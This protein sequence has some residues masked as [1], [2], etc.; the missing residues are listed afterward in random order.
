VQCR[1]VLLAFAAFILVTGTANMRKLHRH[2]LSFGLLAA[3]LLLSVAANCS[4]DSFQVVKQPHIEVDPS[5]LNFQ[6]VPGAEPT[7]RTITIRNSGEGTLEL[8]ALF[9][10][11]A[12]GPFRLSTTSTAAPGAKV[13]SLGAGDENSLPESLSVD[14]VYTPAALGRPVEGHLVIEHNDPS[15][16]RTVVPVTETMPTASL[17]VIPSEVRFQGVSPGKFAKEE[18]SILNLGSVPVAIVSVQLV[19][20]ASFELLWDLSDGAAATTPGRP[21]VLDPP[22]ALPLGGS[23]TATVRFKPVD[24]LPQQGEL[25]VDWRSDTGEGILVV[26]IWGNTPGPC[27]EVEPEHLDFGGVL[28]GNAVR[29]PIHIRSCGADPIEVHSVRLSDT[30]G[31][32]FSLIKEELTLDGAPQAWPAMNQAL[33]MPVNTT[34]SFELQYLPTVVSPKGPDG[35][36]VREAAQILV[37]SST[38]VGTV[39]VD[40]TG[41][42]TDQECPAAVISVIEGAS[43]VAPQTKLRL[44][45]EQSIPVNGTI[46]E[47]DWSVEQPIG[48]ADFFMPNS[49]SS[50]VEITA[51]TAGI[52]L[53][54]LKVRDQGTWSCEPAERRILVIPDEAIHVHLIWEN[55]K[56]PDPS[57]KIGTDMDLHFV[58]LDN[59]IGDPQG[60]DAYPPKP[61]MQDG[62]NEGYFH[63]DWDTYFGYT[64]QDWGKAGVKEDDPSLDRDDIDGAGPE[65]LNLNAPEQGVTY[66]IGVHYF[67]SQGIDADAFF[68]TPVE[69]GSSTPIVRIFLFGEMVAE[70]VGCPM[71]NDDMWDVGTFIGSTGDLSLYQCNAPRPSSELGP[72]P[73]APCGGAEH[74]R[75]DGTDCPWVIYPRYRESTSAR[76][77]LPGADIPFPF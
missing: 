15:G 61:A 57:D 59:A 26:P 33:G 63:P 16:G 39:T 30:S 73:Q 47:Y 58:H 36:V 1:P 48:S 60:D 64:T 69:F 32:A 68:P 55:A 12:N 11:P 72:W 22:E 25:R 6:R 3:S 67:S 52:Y 49:K 41:F 21:I 19:G 56:D 35:E 37:E 17:E 10:E 51:N 20:S 23:R 46:G 76:I 65:N 8:S 75:R 53:V 66:R 14:I 42:G 28:V 24:D 74:Q 7:T 45:A 2:P 54:K 31:G 43:E 44:S 77:P 70:L 34:A 38:S 13:A 18:V 71:S 29:L 62:I 5:A 4:G 27:I 9:L 50:V 40:A